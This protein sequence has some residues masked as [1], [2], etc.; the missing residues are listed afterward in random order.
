[1][2]RDIGDIFDRWSIAKLKSERIGTPDNHAEFKAFNDTIKEVIYSRPECQD[3]AGILLDINDFIW[4]LESGLKS[5]KEKLKNPTYLMDVD[6]TEALSKIGMNAILI[7][8]FNHL[9]IS[10]KN[11]LN[12]VANEGYQDIK[13]DHLS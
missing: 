10:V 6:N 2:N 4:Q 12:K 1:M 3:L 8:N 7:R 5:G 11:H 9:R 13:R